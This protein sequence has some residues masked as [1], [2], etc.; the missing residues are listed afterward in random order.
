MAGGRPS[1]YD[2]SY[3]EQ[4]YKLALLKLT[5][6][7]IA[8]FFEVARST[9]DMWDH[10]HPEF[11]DARAR[12]KVAADV[13]VAVKLRERAMGYSYKATKIFMPAGALAPVYAEYTEHI[14]PDTQAASLWLRNRHPDK[15]KDRTEHEI[16]GDLNVHRVLAE[17]PLTE[18]EW[19]K[20]NPDAT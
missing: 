12:G 13:D 10:A 19:V 7:E 17:A 4:A 11:S 16:T 5:D 1:K 9:L 2:P 15:W 14:P 3:P 6:D 18:D 8:S 20:E